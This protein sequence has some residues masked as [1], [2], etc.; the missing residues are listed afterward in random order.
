MFTELSEP[1]RDSLTLDGTPLPILDRKSGQPYLLLSVEIGPAPVDGVQ[2]S[3]RGLD[4]FGEGDT[5]DDALLALSSALKAL[6]E[7]TAD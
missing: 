2:A 3:L 1:Q 4:I 7:Q 6:Q 5:P